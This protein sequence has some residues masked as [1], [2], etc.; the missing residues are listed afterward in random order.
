MGSING[1]PINLAHARLRH[2]EDRRV[3]MLETGQPRARR[4]ETSPLIEAHWHHITT[5][6]RMLETCLIADV[7]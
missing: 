6:A 3:V 4:A 2:A 5:I 1:G 7:C